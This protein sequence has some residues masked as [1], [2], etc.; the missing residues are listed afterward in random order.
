MDEGRQV[1][2]VPLRS[3]IQ[4]LILNVWG[5]VVLGGIA[6][7]AVRS[8]ALN[9]GAGPSLLLVAG[10]VGI[11]ALLYTRTYRQTGVREQVVVNRE[12]ADV[13]QAIAVD[14]FQKR[15]RKVAAGQGPAGTIE[16]TQTS[17]GALGLGTTAREIIELQNQR[18]VWH[19]VVT[20]YVPNRRFA[21]EAT[22][23]RWAGA[24]TLTTW[25]FTPLAGGTQVTVTYAVKLSGLW[26]LLVPFMAP[27]IQK[28]SHAAIDELKKVLET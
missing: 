16:I 23:P 22:N 11:G 8:L 15:A 9:I 5:L 20:A 14:Y 7:L 3:V 18:V 28:R 25:S 6:I 10:I 13:F 19:Y 26:R 12:V 2:R 17:P 4:V 27:G 21:L 24:R 1:P